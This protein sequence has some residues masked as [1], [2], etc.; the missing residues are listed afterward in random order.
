MDNFPPSKRT[1]AAH[2][3]LRIAIIIATGL[4]TAG[5]SIISQES[6]STRNTGRILQFVGYAIFA[7]LIA[8]FFGAHVRFY[9]MRHSFIPTSRKV[10]HPALLYS[11]A[12][13][14]EN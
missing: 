9:H 8:F 11:P 1:V 6:Q 3:V 7:A 12:Q 4:L 10:W 13:S 14:K 5:G 2:K